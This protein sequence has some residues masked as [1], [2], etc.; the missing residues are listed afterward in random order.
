[1]IGFNQNGQ[2]RV[3][4]NEN[5]GRNHPA[6]YKD[7]DSTDLTTLKQNNNEQRMISNIIN[8]VERKCERGEFPEPYRSDVYHKASFNDVMGWIQS[9]NVV[10]FSALEENK[11]VL[12][13]VI[14]QQI[15]TTQP[16]RATMPVPLTTT[17][18]YQRPMTNTRVSFNYV[19]PTGSFK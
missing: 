16:V 11:V 3:W 2:T 5:F 12:N 7:H 17:S 6:N 9:I 18:T 10:P 15:V 14:E 1:M 19:S 8:V 4:C 13:K